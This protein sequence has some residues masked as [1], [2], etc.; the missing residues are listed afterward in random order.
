MEVKGVSVRKVMQVVEHVCGL[1]ATSTQVTRAVAELDKDQAAWGN[2]PLGE[3][4]YLI[5]DAPY[6]K[7]RH[8]GTVLRAV[9]LAAIGMTP[10]VKRR[11]FGCGSFRE[12]HGT[13]KETA[14]ICC[15]GSGTAMA[16]KHEP[17]AVVE[18]FP[19][20]SKTI[21]TRK[22]PVSEGRYRGGPAPAR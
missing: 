20:K 13:A 7:F 15:S 1:Q 22:K 9:V 11:V 5:L 19:N 10:N 6:E 21:D 14:D 8:G 3:V 16:L 12:F 17:A 18:A 4:P 2:Q